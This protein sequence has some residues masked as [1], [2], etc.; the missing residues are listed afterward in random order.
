MEDMDIG[1]ITLI[2]IL[3]TLIL[4][5]WKL[6]KMF[7]WQKAMISY[8]LMKEWTDKTIAHRDIIEQ[9]YGAY[10]AQEKQA[11]LKWDCKEFVDAVKGD[12]LYG[13]KVAVVSLMNY[14]ETIAVV[15]LRGTADRELIDITLK[16]SVLRYHHKIKKLADCINKVAGYNSWEPV[17]RMIKIWKKQDAKKIQGGNWPFKLLF[18]RN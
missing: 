5:V 15:Y 13:L 2:G 6:V 7:N 17:D 18:K 4:G 3:A 8:E 1:L 12:D 11:E 10:M 16:N 14:F 9:E